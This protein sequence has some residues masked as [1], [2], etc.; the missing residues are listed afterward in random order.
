MARFGAQP[1]GPW[2]FCHTHSNRVKPVLADKTDLGA[3]VMKWQQ[4]LMQHSLWACAHVRKQDQARWRSGVMK[5]FDDPRQACHKSAVAK[6]LESGLR[7]LR[8]L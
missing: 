2:L 4:P 7:T 1:V 8:T 3:A 5:I 6:L